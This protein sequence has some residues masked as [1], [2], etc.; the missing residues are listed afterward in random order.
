[1]DYKKL[2]DIPLFSGISESDY[3]TML[4]CVGSTRG[5][6]AKN[7]LIIMEQDN[8]KTVGVV[9]DGIVQIS[10]TDV[11][12]C[13][14]II[15][16]LKNGDIFGESFV[17]GGAECSSISVT[18][19]T[20]CEIL[21]MPFQRIIHTCSH[22][23][24][25]HKKLEDNMVALIAS[26]NLQLLE[27]MEIITKK[28]LREKIMTYLSIEAQRNESVYFEIPLCRAELAEY[29]HADRSALSRE[30]AKMKDEGIIDFHKSTF[31]ILKV[32]M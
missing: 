18:A 27:K 26:K 4:G 3:P 29:L 13:K 16:D 23:C 6:F 10:Q 15:A 2:T 25:H 8:I 20:E 5:T 24:S 31:R 22:S 30:L 17:F 14:T 7:E 21:F 12:G 9:L 1:M 11:W 19:L 28:T 32:N